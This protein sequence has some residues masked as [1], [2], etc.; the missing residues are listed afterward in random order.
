MKIVNAILRR[1][2]RKLLIVFTILFFS[3]ITFADVMT[4][5]QNTYSWTENGHSWMW[6]G[7]GMIY[8]SYYRSSP[9]CMFQNSN[10]GATWEVAKSSGNKFQLNSLWVKCLSGSFSVT[11][12]GKDGNTQKY[13]KDITL[14]T[15][16]T[17]VTFSGWTGIDRIQGVT[18]GSNTNWACDDLNYTVENGAPTALA[19]SKTTIDDGDP[20]G[21]VVG[22]F[23]T[24]DAEDS[25]GH[26]YTFAS[27]GA[28]NAS[29]SINGNELKT[30]FI[31]DYDTKNSY[32]I[33]IRT[34][35]SGGLWY[36]RDFTITVSIG[37]PAQYY[38]SDAE[39]VNYNGTYVRNG[40]APWGGGPK[41][42][43]DG[44]YHLLYFGCTSVWGILEGDDMYACPAYSTLN[45]DQAGPPSSGWRLGGDITTTGASALTVNS[46]QSLPV[47]LAS[48]TAVFKNKSIFIS[49]ATE[50]ETDHL[51][52]IVER[53][54]KNPKTEND[55]A[56]QKIADY[57]SW[58]SLKGQG[59][60]TSRREYAV[61]DAFI[62]ARTTYVYRLG[63]VDINGKIDYSGQVE[64]QAG[65]MIPQNFALHPAYP[66]PFNPV[67]TI[68]YDLAEEG[69]VN[70][71]VTDISGKTV[72]T[73]VSKKVAA[74]SYSV[75]WDG[76]NGEGL[77]VASGVY[78]YTLK[79]GNDYV[80]TRKMMMLK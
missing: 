77:R 27:G 71:T 59:N 51:G 40:D 18:P 47:S 33:K 61:E 21:T 13:S 2:H 12:L 73:L 41:D 10:Y 53:K 48:F 9:Y 44:T 5:P 32:A 34:T 76:M 75:Q 42:S 56:W 67:T 66:N 28:D 1:P 20:S 46:E 70:L 3:K 52:F 19:L 36:E 79:A 11:I 65:E 58:P 64:V 25:G 30:A 78:F 60:S 49:W 63:S 69:D 7:T 15:S 14:T 37:Y 50:S 43:K 35:D 16:Y 31:A 38:V 57:K 45:G 17:Q 54:I 80:Q 24:T 62:S 8:N 72:R 74:G 6:G 68:R 39:D 4:F 55:T 22:T 23:S 26:T 29:F